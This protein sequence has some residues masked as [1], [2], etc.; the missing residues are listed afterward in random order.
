M[1][2][3]GDRRDS[4]CEFIDKE[5]WLVGVVDCQFG[6]LPFDIGICQQIE[7]QQRQRVYLNLVGN[8]K[9]QPS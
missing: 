6:N 4:M 9:L 5:I 2:G 1:K 3:C 7:I 8:N